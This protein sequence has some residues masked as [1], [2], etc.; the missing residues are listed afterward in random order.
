MEIH[1]GYK[2]ISA[3]GMRV[4][5]EIGGTYL[6]PFMVNMSYIIKKQVVKLLQAEKCSTQ[7]DNYIMRLR[8]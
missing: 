1:S 2:V 7:S 4:T 5:E 6:H 3:N 8:L